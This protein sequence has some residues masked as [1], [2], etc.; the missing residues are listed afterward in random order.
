M[1]RPPVRR[2][3]A[4]ELPVKRTDARRRAV[5]VANPESLVKVANLGSLVTRSARERVEANQVAPAVEWISST[6]W[7]QPVFMALAVS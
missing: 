4:K 2:L 7:M 1:R 3:L 5:K 6:S